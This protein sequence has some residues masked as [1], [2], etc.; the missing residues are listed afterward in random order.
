MKR[1]LVILLL[2]LFAMLQGGCGEYEKYDNNLTGNFDALWT[3]VDEHYCFFEEKG[4]DWDA[5]RDK[6]RA[7]LNHGM[8]AREFFDLLAEMLN[9]L[10]DGHCNLSSAFNTSHYRAWWTDYPQD[11]NLRTLEENYLGFDWQSSCGMRYKILGGNIGYIYYPSFSYTLGDGNLDWILSYFEKCD[12]LIIDIRNNGGGELTNV[13]KLAARFIGKDMVGGYMRHKTGPGHDDFSEPFA[14]EYKIPKGNHLVWTKPVAVLTNR[15]CFSAANDF[16]AVMK[17]LPQVKI[18]GAKT[19]GGGGIPFSSE[20]PIGWG[21][22]FSACPMYDARMNSIENGIDP[23]DGFEAHSSDMELARG[24][25]R[26]LEF[27]MTYLKS[28]TPGSD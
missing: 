2:A 27:A 13:H 4:V 16:V 14:V 17:Q 5:V 20:I 12:A 11:F 19:G 6:Y 28:Q 23:S 7:R 3:I 10:R 15:S 18:V 25:D 22:R 26:I 1:H 24:F 21:I 9:E 8:D